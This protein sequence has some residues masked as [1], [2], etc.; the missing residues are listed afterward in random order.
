MASLREGGKLTVSNVAKCLRKTNT[1]MAFR[2]RRSHVA[3]S[4]PRVMAKSCDGMEVRE[5]E[6]RI[7]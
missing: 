1:S 3:S 4:I 2:R 5:V 6:D 7:F